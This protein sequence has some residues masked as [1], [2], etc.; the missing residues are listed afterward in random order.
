[1]YGA[2]GLG[3]HKPGFRHSGTGK[4]FTMEELPEPGPTRA[5]PRGLDVMAVLGS[6]R[7]FNILRQEGDTAYSDYKDQFAMLSKLYMATTAAEWQQN[8]YWRWLHAL[9]PLLEERK[10][11]GPQPFLTGPA[12]RDKELQT[13]LG[14]WTELR[15]DTI[16]YAKQ[17]YTGMSK[18]M[19]M[20]PDR[21]YGYVEPAPEVYARLEAMFRDLRTSLGTLGLASDGIP[22]KLAEFETVLTRLKEIS[23]KEL[24]AQPLSDAEYA[25]I[26]DFDGVLW[27]LTRFP[28]KLMQRIT[29]DTDTRMDIIADVH[30]EPN[31]GNVLEEAVGSP[32]NIYV[33]V[34]DDRGYRLCRGGVFTYY[35]FKQPMRNRLTDEQWQQM[36]RDK[37]RPPRPDWAQAMGD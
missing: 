37:K 13:A 9:L 27:S 3:K 25:F 23:V 26:A 16:L 11:D 17:S 15:H 4:P 2:A 24:A 21:A 35:E 36:G 28:P 32:A 10:A 19:P 5:F 8:L 29:S 14:S 7:A 1:V 30:S 20:E 18:S 6:R 22:Q 12:W 31:T 33:M 34:R